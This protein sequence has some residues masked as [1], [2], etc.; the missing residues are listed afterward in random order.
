[1]PL[2]VLTKICSS[3]SE[4]QEV[5]GFLLDVA[6]IHGSAFFQLLSSEDG[7]LQS[8]SNP[9]SE[10]TGRQTRIYL[11]ESLSIWWETFLLLPGSWP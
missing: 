3:E 9:V 8:Q 2:R 1:L 7:S 4:H 10:K 5:C 6:V 11:Y